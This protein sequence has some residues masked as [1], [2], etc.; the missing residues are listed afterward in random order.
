MQEDIELDS[1]LKEAREGYQKR[2]D[3]LKNSLKSISA[4][5]KLNKKE[6]QSENDLNLSDSLKYS[7]TFRPSGT[8]IKKKFDS[9]DSS[10]RDFNE[11]LPGCENPDMDDL[12]EEVK[13]LKIDLEEKQRIISRMKI[14]C[15]NAEQD[16]VDLRKRVKELTSCVNKGTEEN[17]KLKEGRIG[18]NV[19]ELDEMKIH[20]KEKIAKM[21][22]ELIIRDTEIA[23]YK[24]ELESQARLQTS[25]RQVCELQVKEISEEYAKNLK[26]AGT[27]HSEE[28][29]RLKLNFENMSESQINEF[30]SEIKKLQSHISEYERSNRSYQEKIEKIIISKEKLEKILNQKDSE[31]KECQMFVKDLQSKLNENVNKNM[32]AQKNLQELQLQLEESQQLSQKFRIE[33]EKISKLAEK[34]EKTFRDKEKVLESKLRQL[35][36]GNLKKQLNINKL[37]Q[38]LEDQELN[39]SRTKSQYEEQL[40]GEKSRIYSLQEKYHEFDQDFEELSRTLDTYKHRAL[41]LEDQLNTQSHEYKKKSEL[42]TSRFKETTKRLENELK[43]LYL[44]NSGQAKE[45]EALKL[46]CLEIEQK[47]EDELKELNKSNEEKLREI[48]KTDKVEYLKLCD[49]LEATKLSLHHAECN[50]DNM[51]ELIKDLQQKEK[52]YL[53][54]IKN[55]QKI[56]EQFNENLNKYKALYGN[57][58]ILLNKYSKLRQVVLLRF[59]DVKE[60][61]KNCINSTVDLF[62]EHKKG[63]ETCL[64]T[65]VKGIN[66]RL[67][68]VKRT[69]ASLNGKYLVEIENL[70]KMLEKN[71]GQ[72]GLL[73][74]EVQKNYLRCRTAEDEN[75]NL[76]KRIEFCEC[77]KRR[78]ETSGAC[79]GIIDYV[80][81][82]E[83]SFSENYSELESC[84]VYLKQFIK[85]DTLNSNLKYQDTVE[86]AKKTIDFYREKLLKIENE[87]SLEINKSQNELLS[88]QQRLSQVLEDIVKY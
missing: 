77:G 83:K 2:I 74:Q 19:K 4:G 31:L 43:N 11:N 13:S 58:S 30:L 29:L 82:L 63:I 72:V 49:A 69:N 35:N 68:K 67:E 57:H 33:T 20:Y 27:F 73:E 54:T 6:P 40:N 86:Q 65:C 28:L 64:D 12:H 8:L 56:Q 34:Q 36:E 85:E 53:Q 84:V 16:N 32:I 75:F 66:D 15:E 5:E 46:L 37:V 62:V 18:N 61:Y 52:V 60:S 25:I 14:E 24:K 59:K 47:Q 81:S 76:K 38:E 17:Y 79:R 88:L 26:K 78:Q 10:V 41:L 9:F 45:M 44:A 3:E 21:R 39:V 42:E 51:Q 55:T 87:K 50:I 71:V 48:K 1:I 23:K 70:R 7:T 22:E 80:D